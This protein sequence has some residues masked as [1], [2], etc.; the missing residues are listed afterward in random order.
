M[1]TTDRERLAK[2]LQ[3]YVHIGTEWKG[4]AD[5]LLAAGVTLPPAPKPLLVTME[6]SKKAWDS[7]P[8][9][10]GWVRWGATW[11]AQDQ[12]DQNARD[13]RVVEAAIREVLAKK[14]STE[15]LRLYCD[16]GRVNHIETPSVVLR[17]LGIDP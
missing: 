8:L 12:A 5:K 16:L 6:T 14:D 2:M 3:D 15:T 17:F 10:R 9:G 1:S 13:N 7:L 11:G 4:C